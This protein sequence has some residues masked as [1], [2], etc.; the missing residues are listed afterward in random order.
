MWRLKMVSLTSVKL[1]NCPFCGG[2]PEFGV[3]SCDS[4]AIKCLNC[5][6]KMIQD[7][8]D[9]FPKGTFVKRN[10]GRTQINLGKWAYNKLVPKWNKRAKL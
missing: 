3:N 1:K 10:F 4:W 7:L 9:K 6:I 8:P 5:R 2:L